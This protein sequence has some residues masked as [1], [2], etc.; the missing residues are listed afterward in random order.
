MEDYQRIVEMTVIEKI[1]F[2]TLFT[3]M[4]SIVFIPIWSWAVVGEWVRGCTDTGKV[5]YGRGVKLAV[6][7]IFG[8]P[9]RVYKRVTIDYKKK[10][11][12][13]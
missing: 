13:E 9:M 5:T 6:A 1:V 10:C 2:W 3:I 11:G 4:F 8:Y 12:V 7:E